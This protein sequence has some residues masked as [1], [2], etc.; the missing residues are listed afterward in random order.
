MT[1]NHSEHVPSK[2]SSKRSI[3]TSL[4]L[5]LLGAGTATAGTY[6][7]MGPLNQTANKAA[8]VESSDHPEP[9]PVSLTVPAE[10]TSV[11]EVVQAV[12]PAVVRINASRTV[13]Q[14]APNVPES[15]RRFFGD[16]FPSQMPRERTRNGVGSGFIVSEDGQI[17]T[18]A[19]VVEGADTVQVTLKDGR[20]FEGTVLGSDPVTDVAVIDLDANDLPTLAVSE[21]ELLPG[22]V[23]IAIGNPLGLDNTVTVG[24]VSATGRTSGQVG[25]PDKRVDFIQTDAAINPG[26]SGGPLLNARGEVIGMNTAIIQGANGIGFAIP[27]DAVQRISTQLVA[28]GKVDHPF[29]GIRMVNLT[30]EVRDS[31]NQDPNN[32][33]SVAADSGV[34]VAEVVPGS[35]AARAGVRSGDVVSQVNGE[36]ISTGQEVQQAVEDNGLDR[37]LRLN[38]DRNGD[39]RTLS[40]RPQPLPAQS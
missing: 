34:L 13:T 28:D 39:N 15:F 17:L 37:E 24:I 27:I 23:A 29:I 33:F 9:M 1:A 30:P 40:L 3:A 26:N 7:A 25:I 19:H 16:Q 32:G 14:N 10:A 6:A 4:A 38:I 20:T 8:I 22:E 12:G 36:S 31:I 11:A 5:V 2:H 21:A 35:P 18:N